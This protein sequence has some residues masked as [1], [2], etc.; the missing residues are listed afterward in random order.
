[1]RD[2]RW[3]SALAATPHGEKPPARRA[4]ACWKRFF[5][6]A[7]GKKAQ[8]CFQRDAGGRATAWTWI[9]FWN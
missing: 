2:G 3:N 9:T 1:M 6:P 5:C 7:T 8:V 4:A